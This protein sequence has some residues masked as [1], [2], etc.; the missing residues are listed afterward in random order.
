MLQSEQRLWRL[1]SSKKSRHTGKGVMWSTT[2]AAFSLPF[3]AHS[4]QRGCD[5]LNALLNLVH[6]Y[7]W[8]KSLDLS[9]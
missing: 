1:L 4:A 3:L 9:R 2:S 8:Y 5:C 6:L 7:V